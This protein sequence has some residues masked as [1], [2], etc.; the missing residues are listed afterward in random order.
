MAPRNNNNN[1]KGRNNNGKGI[2][3]EKAREYRDSKGD[4][5]HHTKKFM[6]QHGERN[7]SDSE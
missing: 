6:E 5:H 4:V 3:N 2:A 7:R 1:R